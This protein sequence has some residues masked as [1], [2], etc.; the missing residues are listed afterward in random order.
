MKKEQTINIIN[1]VSG[2]FL[3][4]SSAQ[5]ASLNFK[6]GGPEGID[7][8]VSFIKIIPI[9]GLSLI[10][11]LFSLIKL[12]IMIEKKGALGYKIQKF[13]NMAP[14]VVFAFIAIIGYIFLPF[15]FMIK[16]QYFL[17]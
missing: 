10:I 12:Q 7:T 13:V 11:Y 15:F 17:Q 4:F 3:I 5:L 1:I 9:I 8:V 14:A 16:E 2:I 6:D